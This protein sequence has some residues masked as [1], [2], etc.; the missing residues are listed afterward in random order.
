MSLI[1][2]NESPALSGEAQM[3]GKA[4][5]F[6][7]NDPKKWR[8]NVPLYKK[9]RYKSVYPG[10]DLIYYGNQK[11]LE[12]DFALS[13]GADPNRIRL[14][15]DGATKIAINDKG[16]LVLTTPGGEVVQRAPV[17]YQTVDGTKK[18]VSGKFLLNAKKEV[19][20]QVAAYDKSRPLIIDPVLVY[21]T[22]LGGGRNDYGEGIAV[23]ASGSVYVAGFTYS[24]DFPTSNAFQPSK[25]AYVDIFVTKLNA[26]G[27]S[28]V[29]ST[30]IGGRYD[31]YGRG[32]AV[33]RHRQRLCDGIYSFG[34]FSGGERVP[35]L[36]KRWRSNTLRI[37]NE[38]ERGRLGPRLFHPSRRK[39]L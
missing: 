2:A 25:A 34:F 8:T 36:Q 19:G 33:G 7:G 30:Y 31:D 28:L 3:T 6:T 12:F 21:S 16:D 10:I 18:S 39:W 11:K 38:A 1:G 22:Y 5:Y 17:I 14:K 23:D 4:N 13:P 24:G 15:F 26:D 27:S 29:Y 37:H 35:A 20:F 32:I 9:V